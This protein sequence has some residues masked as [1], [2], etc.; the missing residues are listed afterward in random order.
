VPEA[1]W[2]SFSEVRAS[3]GSI[4]A[5]ARRHRRFGGAGY[6]RRIRDLVGDDLLAGSR[7]ALHRSLKGQTMSFARVIGL[8]PEHPG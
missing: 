2:L 5:H 7:Q 3:L 4:H 8:P 1:H 6:L